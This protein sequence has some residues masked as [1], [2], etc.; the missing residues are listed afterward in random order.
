MAGRATVSLEI[1]IQEEIKLYVGLVLEN[2]HFACRFKA[3]VIPLPIKEVG[4]PS[5]L[6]LLLYVLVLIY[7]VFIF[8]CQ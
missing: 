4:S 7:F 6:S 8:D 5:L 1:G 3:K 2:T